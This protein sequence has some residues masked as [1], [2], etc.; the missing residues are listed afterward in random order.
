MQRSREAHQTVSQEAKGLKRENTQLQA[1]ASENA[2]AADEDAS[3]LAG[4]MGRLQQG[5]Q[6]ANIAAEVNQA[7]ADAYDE[8][9]QRVKV[10]E[11]E[12]RRLQAVQAMKA[13]LDE[14][15]ASMR[16]TY[17][18]PA[19]ESSI[20]PIATSMLCQVATRPSSSPNVRTGTGAPSRAVDHGQGLPDERD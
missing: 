9:Q 3:A 20:R 6:E 7:K 2:Q 5:L 16:E 8:V 4:R 17:K 12:I 14:E 11:E 13:M 1:A 10:L 15:L 18:V 19:C